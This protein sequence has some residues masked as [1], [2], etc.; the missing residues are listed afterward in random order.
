MLEVTKPPCEIKDVLNLDNFNKYL[1]FLEKVAKDSILKSSDL[2]RSIAKFS[3]VESNL[4]NVNSRVSLYDR[5]IEELYTSMDLLQQKIQKQD[6]AISSLGLVS[7]RAE[8]KELQENNERLKYILE[9]KESEMTNLKEA[10]QEKIKEFANLNLMYEKVSTKQ[11]SFE[12]KILSLSLQVKELKQN[13]LTNL[14]N[15][16]LENNMM[17]YRVM[18]V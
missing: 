13:T 6:D 5:K 1:H 7:A 9:Q 4:E 16:K 12:Q 2:Q 11:L 14:G 15:M 10:N 3:D 8:I 17:N 18:D